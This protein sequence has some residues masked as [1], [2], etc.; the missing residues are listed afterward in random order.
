V[1]LITAPLR[2]DG[3][4]ALEQTLTIPAGV[5]QVRVILAGFAPTDLATSGTVTFDEIGLYGD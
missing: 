1:T 2:T 4:T 5:A 3:F